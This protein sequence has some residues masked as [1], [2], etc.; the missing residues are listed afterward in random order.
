MATQD[1]TPATVSERMMQ[2]A[3]M[4]RP[5]AYQVRVAS[6][7]NITPVANDPGQPVRLA[8]NAASFMPAVAKATPAQDYSREVASFDRN[9]PLPAVGPAPKANSG[10]DFMAKENNVKVTKVAVPASKPAVVASAPVVAPFCTSC[11]SID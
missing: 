4:A 3:Q 1:M 11:C 5:G 9:A 6:L 2:W 7:L 10:T 8:L